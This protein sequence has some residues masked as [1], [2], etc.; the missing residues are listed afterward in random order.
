MHCAEG[1]CLA[2]AAETG[3]CYLFTNEQGQYRLALPRR[4][5]AGELYG[6]L[7]GLSSARGGHLTPVAMPY[8]LAPLAA[9]AKPRFGT[10]AKGEPSHALYQAH[11]S[12]VTS[13]EFAN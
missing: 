10:I 12:K 5:I 9:I 2:A 13:D 1:A 3:C 7:L 11:L 8:A 4:T 6:L